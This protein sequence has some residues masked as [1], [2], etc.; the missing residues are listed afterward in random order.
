LQPDVSK[1]APIRSSL[2]VANLEVRGYV[3]ASLSPYSAA[4]HAEV[5]ITPQIRGTF[6]PADLTLPNP[7]FDQQAYSL[8]TAN[9]GSILKLSK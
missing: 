1:T 9:P 8:P 3:E 5:L 7:D 6:L 4:A 2:E